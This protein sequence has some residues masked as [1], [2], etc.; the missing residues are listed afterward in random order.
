MEI[1]RTSVGL[2]ALTAGMLAT[3]SV[4]APF[5]G[6]SATTV[7]GAAGT[8]FHPS[9]IAPVVDLGAVTAVSASDAWAVGSTPFPFKPVIVHWN[10]SSWTTVSSPVLQ[11]P[12]LLFG[13]AGF[14]GGIWAV[15]TSGQSGGGQHRTHLILRVTGG[16]VRTVPTPGPQPGAIVGV[17]AT[18]ARN[19]WSVGYVLRG[20]SLIL[21]WDGTAWK[22]SLIPSGLRRGRINAVTATSATNAWVVHT[23]NGKDSQIWHWNGR[24]WSHVATPAIAGQTYLLHAVTATS[25]RNAWAVGETEL[26]GDTVILHWNGARWRRTRS[27]N[28]PAPDGDFLGSVSASSANDAWAVGST[29][30][31][32]IL[33][34]HWDGTSWRVVRVGCGSFAG[35]SMLPS[36]RGW[37]VGAPQI[38]RWNGT[39]WQ[40]VPLS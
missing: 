19:A 32:N 12:G 6:A 1:R 30:K 10:G 17:T 35:V 11:T 7:S 15:G 36:G 26:N 22:R 27:P 25:T 9:R 38:N 13:V 21:R 40:P 23:R 18:S 20:G 3:L 33:A 4:G 39:A 16:T 31:G 2:A 37:A 34:E 24:S 8:C 14:H 28:L 5:P 29:T